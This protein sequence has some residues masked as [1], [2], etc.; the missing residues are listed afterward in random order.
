MSL[1]PESLGEEVALL[2][3]VGHL[4]GSI[5]RVGRTFDPPLERTKRARG[6]C[7]LDQR[8]DPSDW[9]AGLCNDDRL[10][11]LD[12]TQELREVRLGFMDIDDELVLFAVVLRP[13]HEPKITHQ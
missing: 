7:G 13:L 12:P 2:E 3:K 4:I 9:L 1:A 5:E 6:R 11:T 8:H 10:P